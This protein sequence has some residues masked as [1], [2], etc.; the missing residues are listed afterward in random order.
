VTV[1]WL[2]LAATVLIAPAVPH[3]RDRPV[4]AAAAGGPSLAL[5]LDLAAAALRSGKPLADAL[6]LAAPAAE[7]ALAHALV[8]V[9]RLC[10]LG[11]DPA[12]AWSGLPRDGPL[13]EAGQVAVRSAAS[14]IR[15]AGGFE[16]LATDLR[17]RRAAAA[18]TRAH[19]AG[20]VALGP[21]AACFLP[22][23]V[24]LGIVP[25][26]VGVARRALS[27]VLV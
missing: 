4:G 2:L 10:A 6:A 26:L 25:V 1:A 7:P 12:Q 23:F 13:A 17:A 19:R 9:A 11:A 24:C 5:V 21:L 3:R 16:R 15:L 27:G 22:S 20:V 18:A 14:G 8:R